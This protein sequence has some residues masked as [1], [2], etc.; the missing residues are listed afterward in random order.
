MFSNANSQYFFVHAWSWF[1]TPDT[2][3][4]TLV[5]SQ[6]WTLDKGLQLQNQGYFPSVSYHATLDM[7]S[8]LFVIF[9]WIMI[10]QQYLVLSRIFRGAHINIPCIDRQY[11]IVKWNLPHLQ[12]PTRCNI[13]V[14]SQY[15]SMLSDMKI[16]EKGQI[17]TT[18]MRRIRTEMTRTAY[19]YTR[20][21]ILITCWIWKFKLLPKRKIQT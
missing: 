9:G 6:H 2:S 13:N 20:N 15:H 3:R 18:C 5:R 16:I 14:I 8:F 1:S 21:F 7:T 12:R 17:R 11:C 19:R 4:T 10:A